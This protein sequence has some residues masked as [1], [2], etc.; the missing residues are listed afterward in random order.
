MKLSFAPSTA[1]GVAGLAQCASAGDITGTV[2]SA[3]R[4]PDADSHAA[5]AD[6]GFAGKLKWRAKS[7]TSFLWLARIKDWRM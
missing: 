1:I 2:T 4:R 3:A 7:S 6:S 5:H